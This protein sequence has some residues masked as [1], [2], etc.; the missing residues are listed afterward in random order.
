MP[1]YINVDTKKLFDGIKR[2]DPNNLTM[3]DIKNDAVERLKRAIK[4]FDN[5]KEK[6][7]AST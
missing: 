5:L 2:K 4:V 7:N 6:G 3:D 1:H